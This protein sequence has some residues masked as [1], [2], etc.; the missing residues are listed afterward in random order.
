MGV[1]VWDIGRSRF[2]SR[3]GAGIAKTCTAK[4]GCGWTRCV[5]VFVLPVT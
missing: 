4:A 1:P 3:T 5:F 2:K